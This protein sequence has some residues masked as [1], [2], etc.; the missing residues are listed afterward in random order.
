MHLLHI[1]HTPCERS[2]AT[3]VIKASIAT[4][5]RPRRSLQPALA[6]GQGNKLN[7][8]INLLFNL[9]FLLV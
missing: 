7:A 1:H 2:T 9:L 6:V 3:P 8:L 5:S 4:L